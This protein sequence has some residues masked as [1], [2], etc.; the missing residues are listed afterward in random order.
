M[1]VDNEIM[2]AE[3]DRIWTTVWTEKGYELEYSQHALDRFVAVTP[4][5][6]IVGT[7]EIKPY[8]S[9]GSIN[10]IA[11]FAVHPKVRS[12]P[13]KVAEF[14]KMAVLKEHRGKPLVDLLSSAVYCAEQHGLRYYV[15]LLEPVLYRAFRISF[16]IPMEKIGEKTFYKGDYVIPTI[17][18]VEQVYRNKK[19]FDWLDSYVP[20]AKPQAA[21]V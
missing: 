19:R 5:G 7:S 17:L 9:T 2:Q 18:D 8:H 4:E 16:H 10:E 1:R 6:D 3:F 21:G 14:D 15:S 11:P 13:G 12:N 20:S